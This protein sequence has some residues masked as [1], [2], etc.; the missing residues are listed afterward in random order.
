VLA[1][2]L[3]AQGLSEDAARFAYRAQILQRQVLRRQRKLSA[4]LLSVLLAVLAGYGYRL[5]RLFNGLGN[6][7]GFGPRT[8][9]D[10]VTRQSANETRAHVVQT[11]AH[12]GSQYESSAMSS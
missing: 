4:Y 12:Y 2:A 3:Q 9:S 11:C 5:G 6:A 8:R 1:V 7:S 10:C